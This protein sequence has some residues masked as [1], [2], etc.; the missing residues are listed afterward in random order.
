MKTTTK[1]VQKWID[2]YVNRK[3]NVVEIARLYPT[4]SRSTIRKALVDNG[5]LVK[6]NIHHNKYYKKKYQIGIYD[7]D[8]NLLWL[9][10][11]AYEMADFFKISLSKVYRTLQPDH[12]NHKWHVNGEIYNKVLLE[13]E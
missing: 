2:L 12:I 3:M 9:F 1:R 4:V 5:V 7:Q 10:D 6:S 8:D 11:N 13:V